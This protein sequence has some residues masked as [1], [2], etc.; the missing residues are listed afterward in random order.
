M[1]PR[2]PGHSNFR[3]DQFE[4]SE[5]W[6]AGPVKERP[7]CSGRVMV[8]PQSPPMYQREE[9]SSEGR[10]GTSLS[11]VYPVTSRKTNP[12]HAGRGFHSSTAETLSCALHHCDYAG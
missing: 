9:R 6:K 11:R 8:E 5:L 4:R 12:P 7:G 3:N 10:S 1:R 2:L